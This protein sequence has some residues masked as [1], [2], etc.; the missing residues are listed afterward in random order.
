MKGM[1]LIELMIAISLSGFISTLIFEM[2]L[3]SK[4]SLGLHNS[5]ITMQ[6]EISHLS[7]LL[8]KEI[9]K[10]GHIPCARLSKDF[11]VYGF[12]LDQKIHGTEEEFTVKYVDSNTI[13]LVLDMKDYLNLYV[14]KVKRFS[15]NDIIYIGNCQSG[16]V[17]QIKSLTQENGFQKITTNSPLHKR[18]PQHA[19][20]A[21]FKSYRFFVQAN[22]HQGR[23]LYVEDI[24]HRKN[25]ISDGVSGISVLYSMIENG[26]LTNLPASAVKNWGGVTGLKLNLSIHQSSFTRQLKLQASLFP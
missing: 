9:H 23:S 8:R 16:E 17:F 20:I 7:S 6:S 12:D 2:Y 25:E 4:K 14:D 15:K 19:Q 11:S 13:R 26:R 22:K 24:Y 18:Y 5:L 1:M 3:S 10:A 21:L